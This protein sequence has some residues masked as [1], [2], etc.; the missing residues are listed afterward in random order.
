MG[1]VRTAVA[2]LAETALGQL[3]QTQQMVARRILLRLAETG[4]TGEPVR[5][6]APIV[7]VAPDGDTDARVVLDTLA[8]RRLLTVSET[9]AEVAHEALLREWPRL[10]TWLDEDEAGRKLRRHLAP[11]AHDWQTR[12]REARRAVPRATAGRGPGLAAR[13][14]HEL[15]EVERDF[16][17]TSQEAAEAQALQRK[18]SIRRLRALAV[19]LT[20]VL[21]LALVAGALFVNQRNE[22][23]RRAGAASRRA[24]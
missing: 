24:Q 18:R 16:L 11:A 23:R 9:H 12:G 6:R 13:P 1:G 3:T 15:T 22:T 10:R 21:V 17:R 4:D 8:A 7:E 20:G 2:R 5:R 14:P 19:G